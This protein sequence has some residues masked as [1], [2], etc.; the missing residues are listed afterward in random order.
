MTFKSAF[1]AFSC[2]F[3]AVTAPSL[4]QA[5][6]ASVADELKLN[7]VSGGVAALPDYSGS[8]DYRFIPF[9]AFRYEFENVT[10]RTDGPGV[11]A[12]FVEQGPLTGGVYA[13]WSGGR[14]EVEDAVVA[15]LP[16][17]GNSILVGAFAE[18]EVADEIFNEFDRL[19]IGARAG[20]DALG[21]FEGANWSLSTTYLTPLS[22]TSFLGLSAGINGVSDDY[23]EQL[24]AI[25]AAGAAASGL[26]V[27]SLGGGI[28]NYSLTAL[29]NMGVGGNWSVTG[30]VSYSKLAG[31]FADSPIVAM[32]GSEDQI[33]AGLAL[34]WGF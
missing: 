34:G 10:L 18:L 6:G 33:F 11:A 3:G 5:P 1:I 8:D 4:A 15:L 23:A 17:V 30:L 13:R 32:R 12:E 9:G 26:P 21:E 16:E 19:V 22:R 31:D 27:Y 20:V 28:E 7:F 25:D 14:D 2:L 24:F 29:L